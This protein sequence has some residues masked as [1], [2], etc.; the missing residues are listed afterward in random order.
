[1]PIFTSWGFQKDTIEEGIKNIFEEI[2]AENF[3]NPKEQTDIQVQ[4][5][6][7]V[8]N[9]MNSDRLIPRKLIITMRKLKAQEWILKAAK[10]KQSYTREF[11]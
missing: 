8:S 4:E 3:A 9:N 7:M 11:P 10:E 2:M 6:Q 5:K 1:M